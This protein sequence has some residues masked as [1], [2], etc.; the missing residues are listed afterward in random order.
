MK[1]EF[2][3]YEKPI[4]LPNYSIRVLLYKMETEEYIDKGYFT[5]DQFNDFLKAIKK[6]Y[7]TG[8]HLHPGDIVH[9]ENDHSRVKEV[10]Y[11][12][13]NG[14]LTIEIVFIL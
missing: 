12:Y 11:C 8:F 1:E 4:I 7:L 13:D 2:N 14:N 10:W 9:D 5:E 6:I 3:F